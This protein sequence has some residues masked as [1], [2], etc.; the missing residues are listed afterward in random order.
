[1]AYGQLQPL[2]PHG[3]GAPEERKF[4]QSHRDEL[5]WKS[6]RL[7][8]KFQHSI[9]GKISEIGSFKEGSRNRLTFLASP[10][11]ERWHSRVRRGPFSVHH[12]FC[13]G[14]WEHVSECPPSLAIQDAVNRPILLRAEN[15]MY[16]REFFP[17]IISLASIGR[18]VHGLLRIPYLWIL[19]AGSWTS[20][21]LCVP[22]PHTLL[23]YDRVPVHAPRASKGGLVWMISEHVQKAGLNLQ[24]KRNK[25][26]KLEHTAPPSRKQKGVCQHLEWLCRVE[27]MHTCF[28]ILALEKGRGMEQ[29]YPHKIW[30]SL[31]ISTRADGR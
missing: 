29:A 5:L 25:T 11:P 1:M 27:K 21:A 14:E 2:Y 20:P 10:V 30:E 15:G 13:K 24:P 6:R 4:R 7:A 8:K 9:G 22:H 31:R 26:T 19:A 3:S 12:L 23:P 28:R 16:Q 18:P 17:L